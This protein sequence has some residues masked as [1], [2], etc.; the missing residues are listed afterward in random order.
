MGSSHLPWAGPFG[1]VN[2]I[3]DRLPHV[4]AIANSFIQLFSCNSAPGAH[5]PH[6]SRAGHSPSSLSAC[7][8]AAALVRQSQVVQTRS[9]AAA[10]QAS[11]DQ[12]V[13]RWRQTRGLQDKRAFSFCQNSIAALRLDGSVGLEP[14]ARRSSFSCSNPALVRFCPVL[15]ANLPTAH[16]RRIVLCGRGSPEAEYGRGDSVQQIAVVGDPA[17]ARP[18]IWRRFSSRISSVSF[19]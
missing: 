8:S 6:P 12:R 19:S 13:F 14:S 1:R 17:P 4:S 2:W 9:R 18:G 10:R 5:K 11:E 15:R 16:S 3:K 7:W